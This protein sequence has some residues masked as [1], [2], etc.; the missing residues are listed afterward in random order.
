MAGDWKKS[1][2]ALSV[3]V[4]SVP[5]GEYVISIGTGYLC[6]LWAELGGRFAG[7]TLFA[8][9]D[10]AVARAGHLDTLVGGRRAGVYVID[11]PG[12]VSKHMQ[13]VTAILE[14][15]EKQFLGR[16]SVVVALGGG[17]VGDIAGFAAAVFKR[18]VPVVQIPTT[19]VSQADSAIGGKT[20]V[21]SSLSKNAFG[22]FWQPAAVY[23]DTATLATM[24]DVQYRAGLAESVKHAA[25]ADTAYFAWLE[26]NAGA[27]LGREAAAL[28][29]LAM[30]NCRIKA[31]VVMEDPTEKNKRRILNYG[32]TIGHAVESASGY[33][34]LHGEAVSIG[35]AAAGEIEKELGLVNDDRSKRIEQLL[36]RLG[37]PTRIPKTYSADQ[38]L[39]LLMRDKKAV[40]GKPR[41][42]LLEALG[43]ALRRDGQWAHEVEQ[44]IIEKIM[45][46]MQAG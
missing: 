38:L 39:D 1:L 45:P 35:M 31:A 20:G 3:A 18:G 2:K 40:G 30:E 28:E 37:L 24:D 7:R 12:E 33:S 23:I 43:R 13:T 22:A 32:H 4:P 19:T 44:K 10:S 34:L 17:T 11:P 29:H 21:D 16:D 15:M 14:E 46:R 6:H 25:I 8:V 41:F 5:Q 36:K 9:T 42:V 26:E 27:L